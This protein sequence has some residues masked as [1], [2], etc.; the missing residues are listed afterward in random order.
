MKMQVFDD[1]IVCGNTKTVPVH[2]VLVGIGKLR[3]F[4]R[5]V[6]SEPYRAV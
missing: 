2:T 5:A 4:A 1:N 3:Q 6:G